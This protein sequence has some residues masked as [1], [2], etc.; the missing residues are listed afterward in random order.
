MIK[1][2][3]SA[4]MIAAMKAKEKGRLGAIRLIQAA[5]KQKEVDERIELSDSDVLGVL[6]K[7]LKQ[8]RESIRQYTAGNRQ[9]LV[10]VEAFEIEVIQGF[11]PQQL[12]NVEINTIVKSAMQEVGASSLKDMGKVMEVIKPKVQ[13][14]ADISVVSQMVKEAL[15]AL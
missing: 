13:G 5:I 10:D 12:T 7:M 15:A 2:N 14:K 3:I 9:D 11:L 6:D 1:Q 8:R 4:A